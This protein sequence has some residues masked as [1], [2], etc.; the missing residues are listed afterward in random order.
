L[1]WTGFL[2]ATREN[3]RNGTGQ[4]I[5][6]KERGLVCVGKLNVEGDDFNATIRIRIEGEDL[7]TE[8]LDL[9]INNWSQ[10]VDRMNKQFKSEEN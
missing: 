7:S 9:L 5:H 8:E 2:K 1:N 10:L 3:E 4:T 6:G